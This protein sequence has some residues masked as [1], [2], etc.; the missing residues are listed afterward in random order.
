M[1]SASSA[2]VRAPEFVFGAPSMI[3]QPSWTSWVAPER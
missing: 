3:S 1:D 2:M